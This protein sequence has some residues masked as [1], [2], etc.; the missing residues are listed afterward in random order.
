MVK[1]VKLCIIVVILRFLFLSFRCI[2]LY[3]FYFICLFIV[4]FVWVGDFF[5]F[6]IGIC[7]IIIFFRKVL[8]DFDLFVFVVVD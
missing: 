2:F 7:V 5:V 1:V 3:G 6:S 8:F 4:V